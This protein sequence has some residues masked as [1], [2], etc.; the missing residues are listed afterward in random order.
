MSRVR[1]IAVGALYLLGLAFCFDWRPHEALFVFYPRPLLVFAAALALYIM[2]E[3]RALAI[4]ERLVSLPAKYW[5]AASSLAAFAGSLYL[6]YGP[7]EKLPHVPD[8]IC[9]LWQARSFA[10]GRLSVG[11]HD[12][13]EFF[14][15][16]FMINDGQW[17]SLFQPGWPALLM[18]AVWP[19][20]EFF[21]NPLLSAVA[22]ALVYPIGRRALDER[23]AKLGMAMLAISPMHLAI[24]ATLLAHSLALALTELAVLATLRLCDEGKTRDALLLGAALGWLFTTRALNAVATVAVVAIPLIYYLLK[25]RIR[26][27]RLLA[28]VPVAA[29]FLVLQLAYNDALTGA[30]LYWPQDRYFDIT[31]PKKGCHQLGFGKDVGCPNVHHEE[32]FPDGF[33][34]KDAIRVTHTRLGTFLIT[35]FGWN[36][37]FF[38]IG[39]PF[40]GRRYGWRKLFLLTVFLSLLIAY[41]FFYFHGLWGR[42]YYESCFAIFL[43][44]A[45]GIF[46]ARE[47]LAGVAAKDAT[48]PP[49][50]VRLMR[51][52]IPAAAL[53]YFAFNVFIFFPVTVE[54]MGK[55]FFG[56][57]RRVERMTEGFPEKSVV[58]MEDWYTAGFIFLRPG[59]PDTRLFV[60]DAG[61]MNRQM[62]QYYPD[63]HFFA[64]NPK[65]DRMQKVEPTSDP[66]PVFVEAEYKVPIGDSSGRYAHA[67]DYKTAAGAPASS[68]LVLSYEAQG[69]GEWVAFRQFIFKSGNYA[70][71]A[72]APTG[73]DQGV[74]KL[75][76]DGV[77]CAEAVDL[78][79]PELDLKPLPLKR[80]AALDLLRGQHRIELVAVG[81]NSASTGWRLGLDWLQ[82][83]LVDLAAVR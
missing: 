76:V 12:L 54:T 75:T 35:L 25:G 72:Q 21:V 40:L 6:A 81:R 13:P 64:Y 37:I 65:E 29:V 20:L 18:L 44:V 51:G 73:P 23:S 63:W 50:V 38:F 14:H 43:L 7:L 36:A 19:S 26:I 57:D 79:S 2:F 15:L 3:P 61:K 49:V 31:E 16:L 8:D 1:P 70:L 34:P 59:L 47:W 30:P 68:K 11:S 56:V 9:Y 22:V 69:K 78:Y 74:M 10:M 62:M 28:G 53:A 55:F 17:Y 5:I 33:G 42:Y 46:A 52:F 24:G 32:S 58:F 39:A 41:F 67:E 80:C 77:V 48:L 45:A 82:F 27:G 66:S 60:H 83:D 4:W 71:S